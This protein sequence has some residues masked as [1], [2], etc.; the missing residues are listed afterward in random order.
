MRGSEMCRCGR[1]PLAAEGHRTDPSA[2]PVTGSIVN[3]LS[4]STGV[5]ST[6]KTILLPT[7]LDGSNNGQPL[8]LKEI[9]EKFRELQKR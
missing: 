2:A 1:R 8:T 6:T 9:G 5:V 3:V 4:L 7:T